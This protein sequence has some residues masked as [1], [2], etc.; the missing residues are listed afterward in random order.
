MSITAQKI[1]DRVRLFLHDDI[2]PFRWSDV[3]L[4]D[5]LNDGLYNLREHKPE[6]WLNSSYKLVDVAL[7]DSSSLNDDLL[8]EDKLLC[9]LSSYV[10]YK[11]LS[12]D[13]ADNENLNR[14]A[15]QYSKYKELY[16]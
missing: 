2:A 9:G 8:L 12:E 15:M 16:Q 7:A 5:Y 3:V 10:C 13:D 6:Y 11:A 14:S 1:I 4:T